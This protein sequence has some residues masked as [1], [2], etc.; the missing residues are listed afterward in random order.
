[1][2]YAIRFFLAACLSAAAAACT[3]PP[4]AAAT[5]TAQSAASATAK[6]RPTTG[7]PLPAERVGAQ[8]DRSC[9]ADADCAVKDV[10]NCCGAMP[11]CVNVN[12]KIDPAQVQENCKRGGMAGVCGFQAIESC[13]C[14]RGQC[15]AVAA[16]IDPSVDP[17]PEK[18]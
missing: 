13:R 9:R 17:A 8:I 18:K 3:A 10:R 15:I 16:P 6:P 5:D 11:A 2:R 4:T 1:M 7:G 12:A 14:A